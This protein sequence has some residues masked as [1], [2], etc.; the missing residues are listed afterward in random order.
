MLYAELL[1]MESNQFCYYYIV[2]RKKK[3][4]EMLFESLLKKEKLHKMDRVI[5]LL[6]RSLD[7]ESDRPKT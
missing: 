1:L 2:G 4:P 3:R 6:K 5:S 7:W